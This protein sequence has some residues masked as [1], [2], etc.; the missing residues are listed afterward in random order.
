VK[1]A[2]VL[3]LID[4]PVM[5]PAKELLDRIP[6]SSHPSVCPVCDA[7][8]VTDDPMRVP[9]I[10]TGLIQ[11]PEPLTMPV[12]SVTAESTSVMDSEHEAG[13]ERHPLH[14]PAA[15]TVDVTG[16][17]VVLEPFAQPASIEAA[18]VRASTNRIVDPLNVRYQ[19]RMASTRSPLPDAPGDLHTRQH[20]VS[21]ARSSADQCLVTENV[22][23]S[24]TTQL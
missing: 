19:E 21:C 7:W 6:T 1:V 17:V 23:L 8:S 10:V 18:T 20:N 14:T 3:V 4:G 2:G 22:P 15:V 5:F 11:L 13:A 24:A 9:A 12:E 16:A